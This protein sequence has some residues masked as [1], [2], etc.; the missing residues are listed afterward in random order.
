VFPQP[1]RRVLGVASITRANFKASFT[2][3]DVMAQG[4]SLRRGGT[5]DSRRFGNSS[6]LRNT[7][8]ALVRTT[9]QA[10][11]AV[12]QGAIRR[13]LDTRVSRR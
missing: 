7:F 10:H 5:W 6:A 1:Q 12:C 4:D 13:P 8:V 11:R 2:G 9:A 3:C